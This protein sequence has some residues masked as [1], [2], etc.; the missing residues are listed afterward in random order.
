MYLTKFFRPTPIG[1]RSRLYQ[2]PISLQSDFH[3]SCLNFLK[4]TQVGRIL[5]D[6]REMDRSSKP[7]IMYVKNITNNIQVNIGNGVARSLFLPAGGLPRTNSV[8]L[9]MQ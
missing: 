8:L 2:S 3:S 4:L 5:G 7:C 1:L 9:A 6:G